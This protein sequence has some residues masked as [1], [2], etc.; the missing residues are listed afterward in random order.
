MNNYKKIILNNGI[1]LYLYQDSSLKQVVVNYIIRYG[2]SGEYF[3]FE[4]DGKKYDVGPGYAHYLEHLLI[5]SSEYGDL[6]N[7]FS[8]KGYENNAY[9]KKEF[10]TY[11]FCGRKDIKDSLKKLIEAIDRPQ[12]TREKVEKSRYSIIDECRMLESDF[13]EMLTHLTEKNLFGDV[14]IYDDS[15]LILG[16][17][18]TEKSINIENLRICYDAFY[19]DK[20]KIL[21]IGGNVDEKEV[22]NYLNNI[23]KNIDEHKSRV[24]LPQYDY[25][26]IRKKSDRLYKNDVNNMYSLGIKTRI[27]DEINI[28]DAYYLSELLFK[29]AY[30]TIKGYG[31]SDHLKNLYMEKTGNYISFINNV[32]TRNFVN[33][34]DIFLNYM[35]EKNITKEDFRDLKKM[36]LSEKIRE[37]DNK[38]GQ[39]L[40]FGDNMCY[41]DD[42]SDID[43]F[44]NL[45]YEKFKYVIDTLDYSNYVRCK[46]TDSSNK[47]SRL[48]KVK[49]MQKYPV[50]ILFTK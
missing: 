41:T 3:K 6:S 43:Y 32:V 46:L 35:N 22:V 49:K 13:P 11:Y 7:Y 26:S 37:L 19:A 16:T 1:P 44:N 50:N 18:E 23:Y 47:D 30:S 42:Y 48:V 25:S 4:L 17:T 38:Y 40:S 5:E 33:Y 21:V 9:T 8:S 12:F 29:L 36:V 20:N 31:L 14:E 34:Y 27:P 45:S 10:T 2:F 39:L 24:I 28:K 15:L